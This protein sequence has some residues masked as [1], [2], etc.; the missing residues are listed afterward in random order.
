MFAQRGIR[1]SGLFWCLAGEH[2]HC[3]VSWRF[4]SARGAR[5]FGRAGATCNSRAA[6]GRMFCE[7]VA[8]HLCGVGCQSPLSVRMFAAGCEVFLFELR[9]TTPPSS[10]QRCTVVRGKSFGWWNIGRAKRDLLAL[11][12][13][14]CVCGTC[15][16]RKERPACVGCCPYT[17]C[18][19]RRRREKFA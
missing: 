7:A 10:L 6:C 16:K 5:L 3:L 19:E 12:H 14:V 18:V 11:V 4:A 1:C 2:R 8:R 17:V 9:G 13:V 15:V